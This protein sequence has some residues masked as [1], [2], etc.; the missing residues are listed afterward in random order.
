MTTGFRNESR[1]GEDGPDSDQV[2]RGRSF[3]GD[4]GHEGR[5]GGNGGFDLEDDDGLHDALDDEDD[6]RSIAMA[7][8]HSLERVDE[9]DE[10]HL[11]SEY[12]QVDE[13]ESV[14]PLEEDMLGVVVIGTSPLTFSASDESLAANLDVEVE[15]EKK[16]LMLEGPGRQNPC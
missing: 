7:M 8:P 14:R 5:E 2:L 9:E 10:D 12:E 3:R 4:S 1:R 15:E 11:D 6:T 16:I 13:P